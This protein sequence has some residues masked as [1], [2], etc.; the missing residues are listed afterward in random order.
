MSSSLK[1]RCGLRSHEQPH[2]AAAVSDP[3]I[4]AMEFALET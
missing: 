4:E 1:D 2:D 3:L